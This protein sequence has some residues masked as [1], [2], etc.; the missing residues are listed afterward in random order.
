MARPLR[1]EFPGAL[2]HV[3]SRGNARGNIYRSNNDRHCWLEVLADVVQQYNWACYSYCLMSNHY[4]I[5]VETIDGNL[6][7][8]M[9]QLNGVY[10]QRYNRAHRKVGHLFQGR[11][12][13]ILVQE[14]AYLLEL[15]R[16]IVLNP[17]R[18]KMVVSPAAW[19]WSSYGATV[20]QV[21]P[22]KWLYTGKVLS[23]FGNKQEDTIRRYQEFVAAGVG[24]SSVWATLKHQIYLGDEGFVRDMQCM[25]AQ[26]VDLQEIPK[27]QRRGIPK[28]LESY[29]QPGLS[30]REMIAA[31]YRSGGYTLREIADHFGIHYSTVS[32]IVNKD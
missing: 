14:D 11:Y 12:K 10:T 9:R 13:A 24:L 16:Y 6:A 21:A 19:I 4:H 17:V 5:L 32:R 18:A 29:R 25:M 2:Y 8:G 27:L 31:A 3:T 20:A 30:N 28:P 23:L 22:P 7:R 1:I 15:C 26:D